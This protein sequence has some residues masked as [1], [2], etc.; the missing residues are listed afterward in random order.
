MAENVQSWYEVCTRNPLM[1][2][3]N[4][5]TRVLT[6]F[7]RKYQIFDPH[8]S[9]EPGSGWLEE[10]ATVALRADVSSTSLYPWIVHAG[11]GKLRDRKQPM[12]IYP[13]C[14]T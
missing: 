6:A 8:A 5:C 7:D 14:Y 11:R 1:V 4:G 13:F 2:S 10:A 3:R 9:P 12:E